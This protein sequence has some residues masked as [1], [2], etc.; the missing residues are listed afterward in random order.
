[1]ENVECVRVSSERVKSILNV[2]GP[3]M[4]QLKLWSC[5]QFDLKNLAPCR[6]LALLIFAGCS[7]NPSKPSSIIATS[8]L[9]SLRYLRCSTC[10]GSWSSMFENKPFRS[11]HLNCCHFRV[12]EAGNGSGTN[13]PPSKRFKPD[14]GLDVS[15]TLSVC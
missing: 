5:K 6:Q 1:V 2:L 12:D 13:D 4:Q 15:T 10:F 3:S 7:F 9:P 14:E 8:F 11:L